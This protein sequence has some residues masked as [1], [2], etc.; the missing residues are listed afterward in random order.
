MAVAVCVVLALFF[1]QT[2][3]WAL[4]GLL[5][6][7]H[8]AI[9]IYG[10]AQ[11]QANYFVDSINYGSGKRIA[12]TFD[13]GPDPEMTPQIL[14]VLNDANVKATFFLIG[15]KVE[16]HPDIAKQIEL[17]GHIVADHS[18]SHSNT[19]AIFPTT[20]LTA[21]IKQGADVIEQVTGKR[22][23]WFRPPF[24]VTNP[25]YPKALK[26]LGM[27]SIGWSVR[28]MDTT[29]PDPNVLLRRITDSIKPG[30]IV[31]LHDT[32]QVTLQILPQLIQ[33]VQESG[34]EIVGLPELIN[35]QPYAYVQ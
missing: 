6:V 24:G 15:H 31:L 7:L 4:A 27:T 8:L 23:L 29:N 14:K 25:R 18:Y 16:Q 19:I 32:Q 17:A 5:V 2:I 10:S 34:M 28:S 26:T 11:I 3:L 20:K 35:K 9:T 33:Q 13:D 12:L 1:G 22:P 21:D 30:S